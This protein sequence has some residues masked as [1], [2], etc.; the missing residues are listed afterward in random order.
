MRTFSTGLSNMCACVCVF[1]CACG[2]A[3]V[4]ACLVHTI[5]VHLHVPILYLNTPKQLRCYWSES[6][7]KPA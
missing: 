3:D 5:I 4:R 1:A 6:D 7:H 2:R